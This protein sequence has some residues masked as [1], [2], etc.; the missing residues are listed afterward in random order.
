MSIQLISYD[1]IKPN[2]D[3]T[4]L[5]TFLKTYTSWARPL[6][7]VWLVKN[8]LTAEETRNQIQQHTDKDDKV[9]VVT[10]SGDSAAW[11]NLPKDVSDWIKSNL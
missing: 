6:E 1:L 9:I 4:Q 5:I 3:Y 8:N 2:K 11:V 10:V 7:S